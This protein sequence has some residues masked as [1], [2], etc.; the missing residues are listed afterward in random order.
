MGEKPPLKLLFDSYEASWDSG[1]SGDDA[2]EISRRG[3]TPGV[4][5]GTWKRSSGEVERRKGTPGGPMVCSPESGKLFRRMCIE[6]VS[7]G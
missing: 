7:G 4:R 6:R 3:M 2:G 1:M 5:S